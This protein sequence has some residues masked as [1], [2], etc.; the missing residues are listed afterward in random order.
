MKRSA[1]IASFSRLLCVG[2]ITMGFVAALKLRL[3]GVM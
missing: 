2:E 1:S 3:V